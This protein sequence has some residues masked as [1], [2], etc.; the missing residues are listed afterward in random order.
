MNLNQMRTMRLWE[1]KEA[2]S[3]PLVSEEIPIPE[4]GPNEIRMRV[5]VCGVCH[6]DLHTIEGD[7]EL[8]RLPVIPGHQVVGTIDKIGAG[9]S[10]FS[11][12]DRIGVAWL[13]WA[14]GICDFCR[15]GLENLCPDALFTGLDRDGGFAQYM[16]VDERFALALPDTFPDDCAAPLLCGGIVGFRA[17]RLSG[18]QPGARLGLYGFGASAH[19]VIQVARHWDCEV[20]VFTRGEN[21]R[22]LAR[23][24]G[25]VWIGSAGE[26]PPQPL[27]ASIIFAPVGWIVPLALEHLRPGGTVA[28][29]AIHMS[30]IPQIRY[31]T[32]WR[33]RVIRSVANFTRKDAN[34]FL[35]LAAEIPIRCE[36]EEFLLEEAN[37]VLM[38]L[39][40]SEIR[41]STVLRIP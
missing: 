12:E 23:Q 13:N 15:V 14:C 31:S 41:A 16:I 1:P 20:Y 9:V 5:S 34:D 6:T 18:I 7:L 40:Q 25:A 32:L 11:V 26:K 3:S 30:D 17:F 33:E 37:Q 27:D 2:F 19:L 28:I 38:K 36:V 22:R 35:H 39:K 21:H 10:R 8:T 29:N 24:L 4:P